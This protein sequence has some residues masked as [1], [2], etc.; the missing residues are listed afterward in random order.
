MTDD[1]TSKRASNIDQDEELVPTTQR[2]ASCTVT[3]PSRTKVLDAT[4]TEHGYNYL[5]GAAELSLETFESGEPKNF[6]HL[7]NVYVMSAFCLEAYVNELCDMSVPR[8]LW[9]GVERKLSTEDKLRLLAEIKQVEIDFSTEPFQLIRDIFKARDSFAHAKRSAWSALKSGLEGQRVLDKTICGP[10]ETYLR[11]P[12]RAR[13]HL[14]AVYS[15]L[16]E[17]EKLVRS[18]GKLGHPLDRGPK[19]TVIRA[20]L[21]RQVINLRMNP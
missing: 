3:G 4:S 7:A 11:S 1:Q 14:V 5:Y 6:L 13:K 9:D 19:S 12:A 2:I 20:Q 18:N 16:E 17:L 15:I 21:K 8:K 10:L